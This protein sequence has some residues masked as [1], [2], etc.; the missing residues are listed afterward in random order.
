MNNNTIVTICDAGCLWGVFLLICSMRKNGMDEPVI[1]GVFNMTSEAE[2]ILSGPGGV[3]VFPLDDVRRSPACCKPLVMLQARTDYITWAD[4]D[5]FFTGNCSERLIPLRDDEIHIRTRSCRENHRV[6]R[7]CPGFR[8]GPNI[9]KRILNAWRKD[10]CDLSFPRIGRSC[11]ASFLSVHRSAVPFLSRWQE[12]MESVFP[13]GD[14]ETVD[15]SLKYY[16]RLDESVLNSLLAFSSLAPRPS[17]EYRLDKNPEEMF[18]HFVGSPKPWENWS[19]RNFKYFDSYTSAA[20]YA[21]RQ[22]FRLP[23]GELPFSLDRKN[24]DR[25]ALMRSRVSLSCKI[26]N[27]I[28]RFFR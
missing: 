16:H 2:K 27:G 14:A 18:I 4:G 1:A 7:H 24:R 3:T 25:C 11:S 23:G 12:Q 26:R 21:C 20:D 15:R 8:H 13:A 17:G 10:V 19:Y 22:G 6:F 5:G 9:P 28:K